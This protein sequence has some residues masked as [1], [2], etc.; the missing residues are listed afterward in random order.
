MSREITDKY[1][2]FVQSTAVYPD[3]TLPNQNA[4]FHDRGDGSF[5]PVYS[6]LGLGGEA[7]EF[8]GKVKKILRGD[9]PMTDEKIEA[10]LDEL[11]DCLW[12]IQD[13]ANA[14]RPGTTLADLIHRNVVKLRKRME[15]GTLRGDGDNR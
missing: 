9:S 13:S 3:G 10:M 5:L 12:Y 7:G 8:Q 11:G 1:A 15:A 4:T 2:S 14:L 6:A